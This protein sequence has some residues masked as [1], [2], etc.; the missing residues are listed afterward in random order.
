MWSTTSANTKGLEGSS[1]FNMLRMLF[2][3]RE[4]PIR[5]TIKNWTD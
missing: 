2:L 1:L 3:R 4:D 5:G